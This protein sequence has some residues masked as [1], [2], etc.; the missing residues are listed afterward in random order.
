[1]HFRSLWADDSLASLLAW[2]LRFIS[3]RQFLI[4]L[5]A[6]RLAEVGGIH[7][8][9]PCQWLSFSFD[10]SRTATSQWRLT[11]QARALSAGDVCELPT[12][13]G[14]TSRWTLVV[15]CRHSG[16][17]RAIPSLESP[18]ELP[19]L[20]GVM[21]RRFVCANHGAFLCRPLGMATITTTATCSGDLRRENVRCGPPRGSPMLAKFKLSF[22]V[23]CCECVSV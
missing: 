20:S 19:P 11:N 10:F 18:A 22:G 9:R 23:L 3:A 7:L 16:D 13:S 14:L 2:Q 15:V 8:R 5:A 4:S 21:P 17:L 12:R 1:M 6:L